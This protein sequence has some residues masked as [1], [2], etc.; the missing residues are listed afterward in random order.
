MSGAFLPD[1]VEVK[2]YWAPRQPSHSVGSFTRQVSELDDIGVSCAIS[3][4]YVPSN[5]ITANDLT[6]A[7]Q[8]HAGDDSHSND[9]MDSTNTAAASQEDHP[10]TSI[11]GD[12]SRTSQL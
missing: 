12:D 8:D 7:S 9:D 10:S 11:Q 1:N 2:K 6:Q 5:P 3:P 4:V